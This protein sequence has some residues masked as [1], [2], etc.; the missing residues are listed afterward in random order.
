MIVTEEKQLT[1]EEFLKKYLHPEKEEDDI[2]GLESFELTESVHDLLV[3]ISNVYLRMRYK[4]RNSNNQDFDLQEYW[5]KEAIKY[6]D[7]LH[8]PNSM[9]SFKKLRE[10]I[11]FLR[12]K[13]R[14]VAALE[15]QL[16]P[17]EQ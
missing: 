10:L 17:N 6:R 14:Q 4:N 9:D 8:T 1:K 3:S 5:M 13:Y 2:L 16:F 11:S 15:N 12:P 7:I